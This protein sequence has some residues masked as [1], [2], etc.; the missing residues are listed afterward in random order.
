LYPFWTFEYL[1]CYRQ[2]GLDLCCMNRNRNASRAMCPKRVFSWQT[3]VRALVIWSI[4]RRSPS[5]NTQCNDHKLGLAAMAS[6]FKTSL[7]KTFRAPSLCRY[8][9]TLATAASYRSFSILNRPPPKYEGHVPLTR[10]E[11]VALAAGSAFLSLRDP[12][13]GGSHPHC[14]PSKPSLSHFQTSSLPLA[15]L[16]HN[17]T[18]SAA[19]AM[20]CSPLRPVDVSYATALELLPRPCR[21]SIYVPYL[22]TP[23]DE[24]T[25]RGWTVRA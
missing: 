17:P 6:P 3:L 5:A 13:R 18:L 15:R 1:H 24:R 20:P 4:I 23:L 2:W 12:H 22:R 8:H 7:L 25:L 11:R 16:P 21:L 9:R 14:L 19:S 10:V